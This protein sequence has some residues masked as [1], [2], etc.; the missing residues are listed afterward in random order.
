MANLAYNIA[1]PLIMTSIAEL[2]SVRRWGVMV[3]RELADRLFAVPSTKAYS[4]VSVLVQ[5][6]C[7]RLETR[8]VPASAFRPRPRVESSFVTFARRQPDGGEVAGDEG[9]TGPAPLTAAEYD[10]MGRL[11]RLAFGQ[12]RKVLTNTLSGAARGGVTLAR[13][14]VRRALEEPRPE[15]VR[16]ARGA[17][18]G[19]VGLVRARDGLAARVAGARPAPGTPARGEARRAAARTCLH[20]RWRSTHDPER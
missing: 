2:P 7:R 9:G 15:H 12:R 19:A 11:V 14:D 3:Q 16:Q 1:I 18:A 4:A 10:A 6:A 13:D 20:P 5:L 17:V 8:A